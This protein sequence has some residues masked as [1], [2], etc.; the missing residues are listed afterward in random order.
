M[1]AKTIAKKCPA[2]KATLST[3]PGTT[4]AKCPNGH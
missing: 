3:F 1:K 4:A 2:C